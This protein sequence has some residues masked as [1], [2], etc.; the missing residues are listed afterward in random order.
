ME[1]IFITLENSST[2]ASEGSSGEGNKI[3]CNLETTT[4]F[5]TCMYV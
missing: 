4:H 5:L 3:V 2:S 1:E